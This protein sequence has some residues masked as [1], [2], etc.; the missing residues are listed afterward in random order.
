MVEEIL[1]LDAAKKIAKE[2]VRQ[3]EQLGDVEVD[4]LLSSEGGLVLYVM[5]GKVRRHVTTKD[6]LDAVIAERSF[7][8]QILAKGDNKGDIAGYLP[9]DWLSTPPPSPP[10]S[11]QPIVDLGTLREGILSEV[12][13]VLDREVDRDRKKAREARDIAEAHYYEERAKS[14]RQKRDKP[15]SRPKRRP[16]G[17]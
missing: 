4:G 1:S 2:Y 14:E 8:L 7:K 6:S 11:D 10:P 9:S 5:Q 12:D 13:T 17:I 3:K 16:F 15:P